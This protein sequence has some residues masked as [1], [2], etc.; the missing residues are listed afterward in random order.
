MGLNWEDN[1]ELAMKLEETVIQF[2]HIVN[3][4]D[5]EKLGD[6]LDE[7]AEFYFP[8]TQPLLGKQRILRFF[9]FLYRRYPELVFQVRNRIVQGEAAAVHW[10]N[11]GVKKGGEHYENEGVTLLETKGQKIVFISDFFKNTEMF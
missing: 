8:K 9:K 1:T 2:F 3:E 4:R 7:E 6:L 10:S 5:L 11:Q